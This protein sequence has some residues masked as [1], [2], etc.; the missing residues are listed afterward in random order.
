MYLNTQKVHY[1]DGSV[2][3]VGSHKITKKEYEALTPEGKALY[4]EE[5]QINKVNQ[6]PAN[7]EDNDKV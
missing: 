7:T 3:A 1:G 5:T 4:A 2:H 6:A